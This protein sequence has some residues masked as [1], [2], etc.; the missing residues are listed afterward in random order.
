MLAAPPSA[1][2]GRWALRTSMFRSILRRRCMESAW[3]IF[4]QISD[5]DVGG[6][7]ASKTAKRG[8]ADVVMA[9]DKKQSWASPPTF[10]GFRKVAPWTS[11]SCSHSSP[12][13]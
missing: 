4:S 13:P 10:R 8:A 3:R 2:F 1:V 6:A 12:P 9:A 5:T 7:H 11:M